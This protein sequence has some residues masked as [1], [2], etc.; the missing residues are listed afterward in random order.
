MTIK[1]KA[2]GVFCGANL[3][4]NSIYA[5][6]MPHLAELLVKHN[7]ALVYG[8]SKVGIMGQIAN[9]VLNLGGKVIGVIPEDLAKKELAH[10]HLT[11]LHY[12]ST[13]EERK[14]LIMKLSDGFMMLPGG[15]G[16]LD[17]FF[18][19]LTLA[20]LGYHEKPCGILN[21]NHYYDHLLTFLDTVVSEGFMN[22]IHKDMIIIDDCP[23][24]LI[25]RFMK[26]QPPTVVR[27]MK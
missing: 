18:E 8:G 17:E 3:G 19:A 21:I 11:E 10:E 14:S 23:E 4:H 2:I 25:N 20:Q 13:M 27:W 6:K 26:Y 9:H 7:L 24:Q 16:S 12:V 5:E 15:A 1:L 22:I